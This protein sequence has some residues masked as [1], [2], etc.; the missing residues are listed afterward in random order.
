MNGIPIYGEPGRGYSMD[1][2]FELPPL[3]LSRDELDALFLGVEMLTRSSG[4]RLSRAAQSLLSKVE[5]VVPEKHT[6]PATFQAPARTVAHDHLQHWDS[7]HHAIHNR[8]VLTLRYLSLQDESSQRDILPLGLF[9]WGNKWTLAAWCLLRH[10]YRDF[11]LDRIQHLT[12]AHTTAPEGVNLEHY[13]A[14][15]SA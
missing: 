3:S 8:S 9:Y 15:F 10:D 14:R 4:H 2:A 12:P 11:R 5:A 7:L 13:L 6:G 1:Q